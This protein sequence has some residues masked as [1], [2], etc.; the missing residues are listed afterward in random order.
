[1]CGQRTQ[2]YNVL[3]L[4][5]KTKAKPL[6]RGWLLH[7]V[8]RTFYE[9]KKAKEPFESCLRAAKARGAEAA[10]EV[11]LPIEEI[12]EVLATAD[13][14][15]NFYQNDNWIPLE[16]EQRFAFT[17]YEDDKFVIMY[18]GIID[19][20]VEAPHFG[21]VPI[22]HKSRQRN[23]TISPLNNQFIGYC[24][25]LGVKHFI[26]NCIGFQKSMPP[27]EKFVRE[28]KAYSE[29]MIDEWTQNAIFWAFTYY[30]YTQ[31][32]TWPM[33]FTSCDKWSGC[34]FAPLCQSTRDSRAWKMEKDY[35][36]GEK[37]DPMTRA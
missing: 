16:I 26:V 24:K 10:K 20:L 5:A 4:R 13:S 34:I 6:D 21:I 36:V 2:Y 29:D 1:M 30:N 37:W 23:V 18:E 28:L 9:H 32:N 19:L 14:Y 7:E 31:I 33:N 11:Q 22:D 25:A 35:I 27:H 8:L 12:V 17:L 15:L 3:N